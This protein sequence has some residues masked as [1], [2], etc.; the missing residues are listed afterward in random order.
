M[1]TEN[2]SLLCSIRKSVIGENHTIHTAFGEKPLVYADYTA[3]GRSLSMIEDFIRERVLPCYA[4]THTEA[5]FTG[6]QTSKLREEARA[7]ISKAVNANEDYAL[8]FCGSGATAAIDKLITILNLRKPRQLNGDDVLLQQVPEQQRPV[9]FIGPY[10]HHSNELP[11]RESIADVVT[12]PLTEDGLLDHDY[13][14]AQLQKHQARSLKIGSFSAASNVTGIK[15]RVEEVAALLH[16]YGAHSFWDYAA[17]APYVAID[18]Q[19]VALHQGDNSKDAV[20]ISPH[21]FIGGPGTPGV[22]VV[23]RSLLKNSVPAVAGGGTVV[24]VTPENHQ[25]IA[26]EERREE[27]GT[28]AIVESVRAGLVFKLQ[29]QVGTDVIEKLEGAFLSSA[30]DRWNASPNIRILGNTE[31]PRLSIVSFQIMHKQHEL[32]YNYVVALLNDLFGIQARGG[33]SCAGPYGHSLLH[34]DMSTSKAIEGQLKEGQMILRPGWVRL[35]FNYFLDQENFDYIVDA[36]ELIALHG[37]KLL[38]LYKFDADKGIWCYQGEAENN[39]FS[40][41]DICFDLHLAP[42]ATDTSPARKALSEY[43][44]AAKQILEQA[45]CCSTNFPIEMSDTANKVRRF[46]LPQ[47]VG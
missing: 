34:M 7:Q 12:I 29:Q 44:F 11:W 1:N 13:L 9:I 10:E 15:T 35:N 14:E 18:M 32:H 5:S 36:V 25:Y 4:N 31:S 33:C 8:I 45:K 38:P 26:D 6:A 27:G 30:L 46:V 3:S 19:S 37:W 39:M 21:K 23:K 17:A 24:Y 47:E 42:P 16:Q 22:L 2:N 20:F 41:H 43:M 40:L 28:P